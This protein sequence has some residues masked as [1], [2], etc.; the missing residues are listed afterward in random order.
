MNNKYNENLINKLPEVWMLSRNELSK[1]QKEI[2]NDFSNSFL[3]TGGAGSGKTVIATY[4]LMDC[5]NADGIKESVMLSYTKA[6]RNFIREGI[7]A[8][9]L[10]GTIDLNS[11]DSK[12]ITKNINNIDNKDMIDFE[13]MR[14]KNCIVDEV[15]DIREEK[16]L[17][18]FDTFDN[19]ML[20]G[21]DGQKLYNNGISIDCIKKKYLDRV[22]K[23]YELDDLYRSPY[24]IL[25]YASKIIR[26]SDI[27]K[28][29]KR[30]KESGLIKIYQCNN[31]EDEREKVYEIIKE[32]NLK[33]V[34]ILTNENDTCKE[35]V[36]FFKAKKMRCSYKYND[37][38]DFNYNN[39]NLPTIL[40]YH[41]AKG[42][43]FENVFLIHCGLDLVYSNHNSDS[44]NYQKALFVSCTRATERLYILYSGKL[45]KF[46]SNI[47]ERI[48]K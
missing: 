21:D 12:I 7:I 22:K 48:S 32:Y 29:C 15:Q 25:E 16:L 18:I 36:E 45:N 11:D 8:A 33:N 27:L 3:V 28:N 37:I 13:S 24:K 4:K 31:I 34:G 1:K 40:T 35:T 19:I 26:D 42:L 44:L 30:D 17:K 23:I 39:R 20:F 38:D 2:I 6:L 41:S 47:D 5:I 10:R 9:D 14:I 43:Q 46:M